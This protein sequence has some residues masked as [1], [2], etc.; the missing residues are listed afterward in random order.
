MYILIVGLKSTNFLVA[1]KWYG[2]SGYISIDGDCLDQRVQ[3]FLSSILISMCP[4][5]VFQCSWDCW[6][7]RGSF[8]WKWRTARREESCQPAPR[9]KLR[10][11]TLFKCCE[12]SAYPIAKALAVNHV[13]SKIAPSSRAAANVYIRWLSVHTARNFLF[14]ELHAY[15]YIAVLW[16]EPWALLKE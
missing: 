2:A 13:L 12:L 6:T 10:A 7:W 11:A 9:L 5:A 16:K 8:S 14:T 4:C 1:E 3:Y 15:E